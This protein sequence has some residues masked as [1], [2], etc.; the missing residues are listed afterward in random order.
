MP[1][2]DP[3]GLADD[4]GGVPPGCPRRAW[5]FRRSEPKGPSPGPGPPP[6]GAGMRLVL[7]RRLLPRWTQVIRRGELELAPA[8]RAPE[9]RS[10]PYGEWSGSFHYARPRGPRQAYAASASFAKDSEAANP[11]RCVPCEGPGERT[12]G[13]R[14]SG[15]VRPPWACWRPAHSTT[16]SEGANPVRGRNPQRGPEWPTPPEPPQGFGPQA[17]QQLRV[18]TGR[19]LCGWARRLDEFQP[20]RGRATVFR[21]EASPC[22]CAQAAHSAGA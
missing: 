9:P 15:E 10:S 18:P 6:S 1:E 17:A 7:M 22:P 5:S 13:L 8:K 11:W 12:R 2:P 14:S 4:A 20:H 19:P 16:A 21:V 3:S